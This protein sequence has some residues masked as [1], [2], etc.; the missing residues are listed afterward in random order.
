MFAEEKPKMIKHTEWAWELVLRVYETNITKLVTF[1]FELFAKE[2][3]NKMIKHTEW[4]WELVNDAKAVWLKDTK[5]V[6]VQEYKFFLSIS[7]KGL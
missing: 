4:A 2:K 1:E 5:E 3:P 6:L 7:H